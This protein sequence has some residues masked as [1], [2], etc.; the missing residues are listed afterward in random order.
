MKSKHPTPVTPP[1]FHPAAETAKGNLNLADHRPATQTTAHLVQLAQ[2][3]GNP[4]QVPGTGIVQL[5]KYIRKNGR[6]REVADEYKKKKDERWATLEEYRRNPSGVS[7]EEKER[8]QEIQR[9]KDLRRQRREE[10]EERLQR[11]PPTVTRTDR[12]FPSTTNSRGLGKAHTVPEGLAPAG[13]TPIPSSEQL[14]QDS[15]YKGSSNLV[16][17]T[18]PRPING[19]QVYGGEGREEL[20]VK[21]RKLA[22]AKERG[23]VDSSHLEVKT[24]SDLLRDPTIGGDQ[25]LSGFTRKDDEHQVRISSPEDGPLRTIPPRFLIGPGFPNIHDSD[26]ESD[27]DSEN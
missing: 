4:T 12:N 7:P 2:N 20:T 5:V 21:L 3:P 10:R 9:Q 8:L 13:R 25:R 27:S 24:S 14:Q 18:G 17:F 16:S 11:V 1:T 22:R 6:V 23:K 26:S 15:P 19:G